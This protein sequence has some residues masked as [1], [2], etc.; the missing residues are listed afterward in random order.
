MLNKKKIFKPFAICLMAL[1]MAFNGCANPSNNSDS[2]GNEGTGYVPATKEFNEAV[3]S[4]TGVLDDYPILV[5]GMAH[6]KEFINA[7]YEL[8]LG[9]FVWIPKYGYSLG[10]TDWSTENYAT[11]AEFAASKGMYYMASHARGLGEKFKKGGFTSG[12]DTHAVTPSNPTEVQRVVNAGKDAQGRN[13]FVGWHA[14]ELDA[15]LVQ[16]SR[17]AFGARLPG[18]YDYTDEAGARISYENELKRLQKVANDMGG[19]L[20]SNQL[21]THHINAFRAGNEVVIAE[22]MEHGPNTELQL[23]YLRGGKNMFGNSW[24]VWVSPWYFGQ[25]PAADTKLFPNGSASTTGGHKT[26]SY[27]HTVYESYVSG[28][29][30]ITN[31]ETEPLIARDTVN[32]GYKDV[33]WGTE[34]KNFWDYAEKYANSEISAANTTAVMI[35]RDN[36]W[37]VARLWQNWYTEDTNWAKLPQTVGNKM[38][39][40]YLNVLIPGYGRTIDQA[41]TGTDLYPG[42]FASTPLGSFDIVASDISAERLEKYDNVIMLGAFDMNDVVNENLKSFVSNG[43]N[44]IMSAYQSMANG[45][46]YEDPEF[47]G[48]TFQDFEGMYYSDRLL[49]ASTIKKQIASEDDS[50][51]YVGET[52]TSNQFWTLCGVVGSA[53]VLA[54]ETGRNSPVLVANEYGRGKV[55][56]GLTEWNL[57]ESKTMLGFFSDVIRSVILNSNQE[58]FA[59]AAADNGTSDFSYQVSVR[60]NEDGTKQMLVLVSH[61]G[62]ED[63]FVTV[64][65]N[66]YLD[67]TADDVT[68]EACGGAGY[69]T[70]TSNDQNGLSV[71][72][73][74]KAEDLTLLAIDM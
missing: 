63:G 27:R 14:E 2:S 51:C 60:E 40:Q 44:L 26:A 49:P 9:N 25:V 59:F 18:I 5:G 46:F 28:A 13:L 29:Q 69:D 12:G 66:Q 15:D 72:F 38:L 47:Y 70:F 65:F 1:T 48:Y 6:G 7:F 73:K 55:Y 50:L 42:Y 24:G 31:Q 61:Y 11:D 32:G 54:V 17:L 68:I 34:L 4:D 16:N 19:N 21:I 22:L 57:D 45:M 30:I 37:E 67:F 10:N 43:G 71:T 58:V 74:V 35:D 20:I 64:N 62:L 39:A 56:I 23:A 53:E 8:D 52:Y 36:G 41:P 3:Y 33:L